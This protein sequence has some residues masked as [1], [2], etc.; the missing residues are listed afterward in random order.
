MNKVTIT[1][2]GVLLAFFVILG[3]YAI[4]FKPRNANFDEGAGNVLSR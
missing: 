1:I 2:A 4:V 3:T